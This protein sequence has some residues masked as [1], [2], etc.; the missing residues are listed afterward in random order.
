VLQWLKEN[1]PPN[2]WHLGRPKD[3]PW[4]WVYRGAGAPATPA[5]MATTA[6][7]VSAP[8]SSPDDPLLASSA[9]VTA[10]STGLLVAILRG[11]L[12]LAPGDV[13]DAEVDAAVRAFQQANALTVDGRVGPITWGT[14]RRVT[15]PT[16]RPT[17]ALGSTGDAVQWL[18]RRLACKP[19]GQFGPRTEAAVKGFQ[20]AASLS[21]DGRVGPITWGALTK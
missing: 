13:F 9:T 10:G 15:A 18:Q 7:P 1:G 16:E 20:R 5:T 4:H 8:S 3:E 12:G 17:L 19:D 11:L 2:G 6:A 14:L 21:A